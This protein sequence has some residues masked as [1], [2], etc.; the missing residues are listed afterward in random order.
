MIRIHQSIFTPIMSEDPVNVDLIYKG[1]TSSPL[2]P[3]MGAYL[4]QGPDGNFV[5]CFYQDFPQPPEQSTL[6][7]HDSKI[8]GQ[9]DTRTEP[10]MVRQITTRVVLS[11]ENAKIIG[12][13][14]I[15]KSDAAHE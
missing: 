12:E 1:R 15:R 3:A 2:H 11:K 7:I 5:V 8:I 6:S 9:T 10:K 4:E 13:F 14:L